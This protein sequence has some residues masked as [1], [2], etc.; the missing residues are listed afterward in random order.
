MS[1][2]IHYLCTKKGLPLTFEAEK[3]NIIK[4]WVGIS[5]YI[6][7]YTKSHSDIMMPLGKG[8]IYSEYSNQ[9]LNT[10]RSTVTKIVG[11]DGH[12]PEVLCSRIFLEA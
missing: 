7:N 2:V 1:R 9:K 10:R 12:M 5:F 4:W 8:V 11:L 6:H 3:S